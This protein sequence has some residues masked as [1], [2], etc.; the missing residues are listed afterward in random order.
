[1]LLDPIAQDLYNEFTRL[2][3]IDTHTHL[4]PRQPTARGLEDLLGCPHYAELALATGMDR[5]MLGP[6]VAPRDRV[7]AVFYHLIDFFPNT[8]PYLWFTEIARAFLGFQRERL[9]FADCTYLYDAAERLMTAP[10][11]ER[12]VLEASNLDKAF[13]NNAFDDP[14]DGFDTGRYVP[15]LAAD[16]LVFGLDDAGVRDRLARVSGVEVGDP[17]GLQHTLATRLDHF[18]RHGARA[19]SLVA[20]LNFAPLAVTEVELARAL[21]ACVRD[22]GAAPADARRACAYGAFRMLVE[23]CRAFEL[24]LQLM[25]GV[26]YRA[27][28]EGGPPTDLFDAAAPVYAYAELF[29]TFPAVTFCVSV[30][31]AG[32]HEELAYLSKLFANVMTSGHG[33]D[34]NNVPAALERSVRERLQII[35]QVKLIGFYSGMDR[36]EF[37]LP[38]FNMYRRVLA[39]TLATH[40]VRPRVCTL[41]QA[42]ALGRL[43]LR[44]NA[45]RIFDV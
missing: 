43:L 19:V 24:P 37:A 14:L 28:H 17:V 41:G 45:R 36:L 16:E 2:P 34:T 13:L 23:Q 39:Q 8:L 40:Y 25:V 9:T 42:V 1:M 27:Y 4:D 5:A 35:P 32:P 30:L 20:P 11:W 22:G 31:S 15:C 21:A 44:D 26:S 12:R 3:I 29:R 18:R 33:G 10:G 7:R 38:Q 6:G